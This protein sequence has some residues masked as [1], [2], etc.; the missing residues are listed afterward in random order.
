MRRRIWLAAAV[1]AALLLAVIA[2]VVGCVVSPTG[3]KAPAAGGRRQVV[4]TINGRPVYADDLLTS[5]ALRRALSTYVSVTVLK[6]DAARRGVKVDPEELKQRIEDLKA[7]MRSTGKD[8]NEFLKEQNVTEQDVE[9]QF[10]FNLL[11]DAM[12]DAMVE[13]TDDQLKQTWEQNKEQIVTQYL[14]DNK[15]PDTEKPK[16]TYEQ[17]KALVEKMAK[18]EAGAGKQGE[19][20]DELLLKTTIT[21]DA[22]KDPARRKLMEDLL[23]NNSKQRIEEKKKG[24]ETKPPVAAPGTQPPATGGAPSAGAAGNGSAPNPPAQKPAEKKKP[25]SGGP[26]PTPGG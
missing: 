23:V 9:E 1:L 17:C 10:G 22:I 4:M 14:K 5:L 24:P 15:L 26:S 25:G 20:Q 6:E 12:L 11:A 16:V 2:C 7:Q 8:W 3:G 21:L 18:R 13:V 19:L